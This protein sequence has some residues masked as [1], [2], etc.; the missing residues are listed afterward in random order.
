LEPRHP[1]AFF[2]EVLPTIVA[3][4]EGILKQ[5]KRKTLVRV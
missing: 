4:E 2:N 5:T 1:V 3:D